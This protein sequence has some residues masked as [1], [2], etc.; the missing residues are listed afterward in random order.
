VQRS[1][2]LT[3]VCDRSGTV[4]YAS[5]AAAELL[6][7]EGVSLV[8]GSVGDVVA[9]E[10]RHGL[11]EWVALSG[12]EP[13]ESN[14]ALTCRL[15]P[16]PGDGPGDGRWAEVTLTDL[17]ADA[18]VGGLM[19]R[20]RD[21]TERRRLE[22]ALEELA[23]TDPLTGMANR[24]RFDEALRSEAERCLRAGNPLTLMLLDIDHFKSVNDTYG[25][26]VGDAGAEGRRRAV[27]G[28]VRDID[29]VA[30]VGGEEFAVLLIDVGLHEGR[31]VADR[32]RKV[33][34]ATAGR[35]ARPG[36]AGL[37]GQPR[38][39]RV[40]RR[41]AG[42]DG[43]RRR[44]PVPG[45][46]RGPKP[47]LLERLTG[48]RIRSGPPYFLSRRDQRPYRDTGGSEGVR[49]TEMTEPVARLTPDECWG[50]LRTAQVGRLAVTV[51]GRPEIFPV[52][53]V[54]GPRHRGLPDGGGHQARGPHGRAEVAF[55]AD[56]HY[57]SGSAD[58]DRPDEA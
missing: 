8:G 12:A 32:M 46:G 30:R 27:P 44:R 6:G 9:A 49:M 22:R 21:V 53:Y 13:G 34:E 5:S 11:L 31:L 45:E 57:P 51:G 25:H 20:L 41:L 2:E 55:E 17:S 36:A 42:P 58:P 19:L 10:D 52:N 39:G 14:G 3:L 16:R 37:H 50:L 38:R 48:G 43:P 56:G 24:R 29:L 26:P 15:Q 28:A 4:S 40:R 18:A 7:V 54:V 23:T 33:I 1:S 47:G 35:P